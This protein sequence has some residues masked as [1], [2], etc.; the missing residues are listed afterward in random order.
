MTGCESVVVDRLLECRLKTM[1]TEMS[2]APSILTTLVLCLF[3]T[4]L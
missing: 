4:I 1:V 3:F 2:T